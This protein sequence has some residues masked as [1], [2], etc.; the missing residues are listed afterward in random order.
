MLTA[1]AVCLLVATGQL[2]RA[3]LRTHE[4]RFKLRGLRHTAS[5]I[6]I[7]GINDNTNQ[8]WWEPM[9]FWG[10]HYAKFVRESK[11]LGATLI[12]FDV[13]PWI[14]TDHFL[15][16]SGIQVRLPPDAD[17]LQA[18]Q[19][20]NGS[21]VL[22]N[23]R[24]DHTVTNPNNT[25]LLDQQTIDHLGFV[26]K[27][28]EADQVIHR[29]A[30]YDT[31]SANN[32]IYPSFIAVL[33]GLA[34][35]KDP[36]NSNDLR[37]L[38]PHTVSQDGATSFWINYTGSRFPSIEA[39]SI[40]DGNLNSQQRDQVRGSIIVFGTNYTTDSDKHS[41]VGDPS[42]A[43]VQVLAQELSTL[44]DG[45]AL[46]RWS[47]NIEALLTL[48]FAILAALG[49]IRLS[50]GTGLVAGLS[51]CLIW[52]FVSQY[53]F[54]H[55]LRLLPIAGPVAA[56]MLPWGAFHIV[57]SLEESVMRL[58]VESV[59][60][61][62]VSPEIKDYLLASPAHRDL[63]QGAQGD[64]TVLFV[65]IKGFTHLVQRHDLSTIMSELNSFFSNLSP[66][67]D[68]HGGYL[69]KYTGDG[70]MAIF[71][72]P[73]RITNH[74]QAAVDA[75]F[76]ICDNVDAMNTSRKETGSSMWTIRC[77]IHSGP[78]VYG[79]VGSSDRSEF[80]VIGDTVNLASRLEAL[81]KEMNSRILLSAMT[82]SLLDNKPALEGPIKKEIRGRDGV[83]EVYRAFQQHVQAVDR[84]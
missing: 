15:D 52:G 9:A 54:V 28:E 20:A 14:D 51:F 29:A 1:F 27:L 34:R 69:N 49:N 72:A 12:G 65:D 78:V 33:A 5:R 10:H 38:A 7:A 76:E 24:G 83:V 77:G 45:A 37:L 58:R 36:G 43:G 42:A 4:M 40:S 39:Q 32:H 81:N 35:G 50:F 64:A 6:V 62:N 21:V 53:E 23:I 11:R 8:T 47:R 25:L 57:R 73:Y 3:E 56:V 18:I 55:S 44:L 13:V 80:T 26:N 31:D 46:D 30:L 61:R 67:V 79:N 74:A 22:S 48:A 16:R 59:F 17:F 66:I 71:G 19:D 84:E 60:G 68:L 41:I 2:E 63:G 82:Y 70:F 75:A